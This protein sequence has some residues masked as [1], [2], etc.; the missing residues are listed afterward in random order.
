MVMASES[1]VR[2]SVKW[3]A[4]FPLP[5]APETLKCI[6]VSAGVQVEEP[7]PDVCALDSQLDPVVLCPECYMYQY[8][9]IHQ[10]VG[11][12]RGVVQTATSPPPPFFPWEVSTSG[13]SASGDPT[14]S[15]S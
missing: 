15:G 7:G 10:V 2:L 5:W 14:G 8:V 9:N 13:L 1:S 6:G 3:G 4:S 12:G 11:P